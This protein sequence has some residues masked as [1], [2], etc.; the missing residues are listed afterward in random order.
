MS[1]RTAQD[2]F[3]RVSAECA[4]Q[5]LKCIHHTIDLLYLNMGEAQ[6]PGLDQR[7]KWVRVLEWLSDMVLEQQTS[8]AAALDPRTIERMVERVGA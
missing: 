2:G 5:R 7:D 3:L 4:E 6:N 1:M 8:L